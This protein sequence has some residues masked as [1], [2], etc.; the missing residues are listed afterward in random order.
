[1]SLALARSLL[2]LAGLAA[3]AAA[4]ADASS[5]LRPL[6][7][8]S[9]RDMASCWGRS[10]VECFSPR[11]CDGMQV[12]LAE[13]DA[14]API[15]SHL[16]SMERSARTSAHPPRGCSSDTLSEY[17][18]HHGDSAS[19]QDVSWNVTLDTITFP[20]LTSQQMD[21]E[22]YRG[23]MIH[24]TRNHEEQDTDWRPFSP[25]TSHSWHA[26]ASLWHTLAELAV[27]TRVSLEMIHA[28]EA[29]ALRPY[30]T[31][32][33]VI[34]YHRLATDGLRAR[35]SPH[36]HL[37][38]RERRAAW[39]ASRPSR[40]HTSLAARWWRTPA[41]R[42]PRTTPSAQP[43]MGAGAEEGWEWVVLPR[44]SSGDLGCVWARTL[45]PKVT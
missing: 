27:G 23:W 2:L 25:H 31:L 32:A 8:Q 45:E 10:S 11:L 13:A 18:A 36:I 3:S 7:F 26:F 1:M 35:L 4:A 39:N 34:E 22:D 6:S 41:A 24:T 44:I 21:A 14:S 29:A 38:P 5:F 16:N 28:G 19:L 40:P 33:C 37:L 30:R 9:R 42:R 43:P 15:L 12:S 20:S 17:H